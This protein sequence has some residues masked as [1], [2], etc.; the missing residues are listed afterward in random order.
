[1]EYLGDIYKNH[2]TIVV[3]RIYRELSTDQLIIQEWIDGLSATDVL[4]AKIDGYSPAEYVKSVTG[5]DIVKVLSVLGDELIW[6]AFDYEMIHGDPHPGNI[7]FLP[8]NKIALIDYGLR[9]HRL[10]PKMIRAQ[11]D[12]WQNDLDIYNGILDPAAILRTFMHY[13]QY[14]LYK[15]LESIAVYMKVDINDVFQAAF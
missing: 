14:G 5:S 7:R 12:L 4:Q 13:Q 6:G 3:P 2:E 10:S 9:G 11:V 15:A 1:M 8:N